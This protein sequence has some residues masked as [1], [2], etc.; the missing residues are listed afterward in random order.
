MSRSSQRQKV[1]VIDDDELNRE[2]MEEALEDEYEVHYAD[3]GEEGLQLARTIRPDLVLLDIMMPG[4][5]GYECCRQIRASHEIGKAK[6]ILVSAKAMLAERMRGYEAGADDYMTKPFDPSELQAKVRVYAQLKN[7]QEVDD[8]KSNILNLLRHE[9]RTP[10]T[11]I[12]AACELLKEEDTLT[13]DEARYWAR[14]AHDNAKRLNH[15][16]EQGTLL[17]SYKSGAVALPMGPLDLQVL[18]EEV[19]REHCD[20]EKPSV[21]IDLRCSESVWINA[22]AEHMKLVVRVL[23]DNGVKFSPESGAVEL[24]VEKTDERAI[25]MVVDHGPGITDP[26][27]AHVFDG[28]VTEDIAHHSRG[29]GLNLALGRAVVQYHGGEISVESTPDVETRFTVNL[30]LLA[31]AVPEVAL[32]D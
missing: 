14:I 22:N 6:I 8:L 5:D 20:H 25:L 15:F 31:A 4:M 13:M 11:G 24:R 3:S 19:V 2:I 12:L 32:A 18:A 21:R 26:F 17:C 10:L 7:V 29:M 1:L 23:V 16:L 30:P 27:L 28:F 9:T